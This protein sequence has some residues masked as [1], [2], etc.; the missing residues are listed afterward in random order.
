[1]EPAPV[2]RRRLFTRAAAAVAAGQVAALAA[3]R[4]ARGRANP[5]TTFVSP[6]LAP[7]VDPLPL[8]PTR[9]AAGR[10]VAAEGRH[11]FHRD[12]P[13]QATWG[14]DGRSY[15]G[16]V[17]EARRDDP[18][19][20]RLVNRLGDH[21]LADHLDTSLHGASSADRDRPRHVVHLHGAVTEPGSD[22]H[23]LAT[24][25]PG[26]ERAYHYGNHQEAA[27]LW[28]HD[29]AMGITRL[30]VWCGLAGPYLLR[31]RHDTGRARNPLG[32]PAGAW[33]IPLVL[34]D[35][36]FTPDG[37]LQF[38][39]ATY[40]RQGRWE[41]GQ[42]GDVAVVNGAVTPDLEVARGLY[43]FRIVNAS[44]LRAYVLELSHRAPFFVIGG[45]GGLLDAPVRTNR[46]RIAAGERYDV[47]VDFSAH[48]PGD[49]IELVNTEPLSFQF[50]LFGA[51]EVHRIMRFTV[52]TARGF[53]GGVP[54]RLRGGRRRPPRLERLDRP[55]LT[56][57]MTLNQATDLTTEFPA[58]VMNLN[59]LP[60]ATDD[61]E[62]PRPGTVERWEI[63]NTT[64]D[65]HPVHVHVATV[66]VEHRRAFNVRGY[67]A[68]YPLPPF[69]TRWTPDPGPF[70]TGGPQPPS[71][72]ETG[73]KDTVW[74]PPNTVT[75]IL[76]RWPSLEE[77]RFDPDR[78]F[79]VPATVAAGA[80]GDDARGPE[81]VCRLGE[82][83]QP[84]RTAT[85]RGYVWHCHVI[86]HED[87]DMMLPVRLG[88]PA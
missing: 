38:R 61:V 53:R 29:H 78:L 85:V 50:Q 7:Y 86:D 55:V 60:F 76:V 34:Q 54:E 42:A 39:T 80:P 11:R 30:N 28:Y 24:I 46:L 16:P 48:R 67:Q 33:E 83:V 52:G 15:L 14:Y 82:A 84:A 73:N 27:G 45:D 36:I 9:P 65:D 62:H 44:N 77:L 12:L 32:L 5:L 35:R 40:V 68:R 18:V 71:V 56:R 47:L 21:L 25:R 51:P 63:V 81:Y 64:T 6:D 10:L 1:M 26:Q 41:G 57:R 22:G 23:P 79:R 8:L 37:H 19:R 72:W 4:F 13:V 3:P 74:C 70:L 43:R 88:A 66:R 31:D 49:R 75:S 2:T 59:N 87:H 17:L 69:G 20:V 58:Q